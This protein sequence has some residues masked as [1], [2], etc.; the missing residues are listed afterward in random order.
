MN[1]N[2]RVIKDKENYTIHEVYYNEDG[3]IWAYGYNQAVLT[4]NNPEEL[5]KSLE[6]MLDS[7]Q[8]EILIKDDIVLK[9]KNEYVKDD[10]DYL[11]LTE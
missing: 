8:K 2:Y 3:S 4:E 1:W 7:F 10:E 5:K 6:S 11:S 9:E